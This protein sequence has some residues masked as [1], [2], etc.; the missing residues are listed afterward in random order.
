MPRPYERKSHA[1]MDL[2]RVGSREG[3]VGWVCQDTC[4]LRTF[5]NQLEPSGLLRAFREHPPEGFSIVDVGYDVPAFETKFD[6]LTTLDPPVLRRLDRIPLSRWWRRALRPRTCFVGTTVSEFALLPDDVPPEALVRQLAALPFPFAIIKD[7]PSEPALV[8][9]AAF[10]HSERVADAARANGFVMMEGQALA[11]VPID[12]ASTDEYLGRLS[13][14]RRKNLRRKLKS[15]AALEIEAV[16]AG[17]PRFR[18]DDFLARLYA[19][20]L[21]VYRQSE[22]H[23]DL[24]T[25]AF[26]RAVLQDAALDGIV[27]FY[28]AEG[29]L[30]A[31]N[32]CVC[33]D[34]LLIDKYIGFAYPK[35][36]D[37]NLYAVSWMH[38]LDYAVQRGLRH[39]VAGWTDPEIKRSL[40]ARFT[41]TR[42][43]VRPRN[44]ILRGL[45]RPLRRFFESDRRWQ[46]SHD[47]R[48][49]S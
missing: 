23:F 32:L 35:S 40:G 5:L 26:F 11:Y 8:G 45:L 34:G 4:D 6:L 15:R 37:Y 17:D 31:Y 30:I 2:G 28:R 38:N 19:L 21:D 16:P 41:F 22:I 18:D 14:A 7:L 13:H 25:P 20:Y 42:H 46:E 44:R 24:L 29:E 33:R 48:A 39:Y 36:R 9:E 27:F 49:E 47:E 12:F 10:A 1:D 43:A 3:R